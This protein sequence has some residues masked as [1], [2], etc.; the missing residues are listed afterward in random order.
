MV[1]LLF[2][3]KKATKLSKKK[4][5]SDLF[6]FGC[7]QI[8]PRS[9]IS[10]AMNIIKTE[11]AKILSLGIISLILG[12]IFVALFYEQGFGLNYSLFMAMVVAVGLLLARVFSR[13]LEGEQYAVIAA[14]LFFS[15][16]VF[17]RSSEPLTF[18]N[19]L[20][21][22]LLLLV[23][24]QMFAGGHM[25]SFVAG[26]Y[27]KVLFLPFSFIRPFFETFTVI[28]FPKK[29]SETHPRIKEIIRGS[30]MSAVA[31]FV[32]AGLFA[33]ADA[34]FEKLLSNIFSLKIDQ[35]MVDQIFLGAFVAA[36]FVGG[37][38]YMFAKLHASPTSDSKENTRHLGE[39]ETMIL[40]GSINALFVV[41]IILQISYLFGG[42][43]HLL[44]QGLTY[45]EYAREGFFQLVVVAILSFI[46]IAF[47]ERQIIQ[48]DGGHLRSF[49][50]LCGVLVLQVIAILASAFTRLSLY[51][52]AYGFTD[53]RLYSHAFMIWLGV[54]LLL[55][56]L[57][58]AKNGKRA[59]FSFRVF[60]SVVVL[61]FAMNM[62]NPDAFIAKENLDRYRSTGLLDAQYLGSLSDDALPL[63][64]HL[65][66]DPKEEI[67]KS[68]AE[69]LYW[70][71]YGEG[72]FCDSGEC[73]NVPYRSWQSERLN[74]PK[75]E[76]LLAPVRDRLE[77]NKS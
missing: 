52:N 35:D 1:F 9:V 61:L 47:A 74:R 33:S 30:L 68:F 48:N 15:S 67:R 46:L 72:N 55:L 28:I 4:F 11:H 42:A 51:E 10:D 14:G 66:D 76:K 64:I 39:I 34:G 16:M 56:A 17:V 6:S 31:L 32:F 20:G 45:S 23:A 57:H 7:D 29:L 8:V 27:L 71:E 21:S 19:V 24:V 13:R 38:S 26:D 12:V 3:R 73:E 18:F 65:L 60:C 75:A 44:A 77:E 41:F 25:R 54:V 62:L 59:E 70:K 22:L 43:S 53:T 5:R 37:F 50:I 58:I 49:K 40:L 2:I 63:T 36:F 69:G